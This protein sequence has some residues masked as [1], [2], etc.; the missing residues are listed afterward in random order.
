[1]R[2]RPAI[3]GDAAACAAIYAPVVRDTAISFEVVAPDAAETAR[4]IEAAHVWLVA[5]APHGE[6]V[7]YAYSSPHRERAA[8]R[9]AVDVSV[10]VAPHARGCG[11]AGRLY[12]DLLEQ[13]A[14]LGLRRAYAGIALPNPASVAL[15][16][17]AGFRPVGV[18]ERV[19]WKL[20]RWH[21]VGW[22]Q[23]DLGDDP[24]A[25]PR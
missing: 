25:P 16:E 9:Y 2:I 3:A 21:D 12:E 18:Y 11:I 4:R 17:S 13:T 15:H 20:G 14:A 1:M 22:W 8:Y 23:R 24:L 19:G 6:V 7:G 5:V 10:Y